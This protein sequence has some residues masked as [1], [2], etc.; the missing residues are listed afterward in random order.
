MKKLVLIIA[1]VA[2]AV[3]STFAQSTAAATNPGFGFDVS[4]FSGIV[5]LV[6][7]LVTEL[8][9]FIP[10][11]G[12]NNIVK[13]VVSAVVGALATFIVWKLGYAQFLTGKEWY[14]VLIYG[15]AAGLSGCGVFSVIKESLKKIGVV[16]N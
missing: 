5:A 12:K 8:V 11:V 15:L 4:T 16:L 14:A 6:S 3:G 9:K 7:W 13:I 10:Q 2:L 1:M